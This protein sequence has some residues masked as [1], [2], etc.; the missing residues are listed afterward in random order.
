MS[1]LLLVLD[2]MQARLEMRWPRRRMVL[3]A[4]LVPV[5]AWQVPLVALGNRRLVWKHRAWMLLRPCRHSWYR[6]MCLTVAVHRTQA[7]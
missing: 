1:L 7:V 5:L 3:V 6:S 4:V 2:Q